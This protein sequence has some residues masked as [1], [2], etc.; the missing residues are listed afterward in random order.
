MRHAQSLVLIS[1]VVLTACAP[2]VL[3]PGAEQV[4]VTN[5]SADVAGC[6][7]VGNIQMPKDSESI[8]DR[9]H[10]VARMKNQTIG[11]GGNTALVTES[12]LGTPTAGVAYRCP[13]G[14]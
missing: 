9:G 11:Y 6:T 2:I 8:A 3:A 5:V 10:A 13:A 12:E 4:R 1:V 14:Q 7:A